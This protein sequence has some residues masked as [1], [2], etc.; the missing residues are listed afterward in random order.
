MSY[1]VIYVSTNLRNA[2]RYVDLT[3]WQ[4]FLKYCDY[5]NYNLFIILIAIYQSPV[6]LNTNL[7]FYGSILRKILENYR[8]KIKYLICM[9]KLPCLSM[10]IIMCIENLINMIEFDQHWINYNNF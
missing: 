9:K 8:Q 10:P 5:Y 6:Y 3:E 2:L 7:Y 1:I 4:D